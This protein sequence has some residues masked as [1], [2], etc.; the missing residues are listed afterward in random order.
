[1]RHI[2]LH[3]AA[4]PRSMA[5]FHAIGTAADRDDE[6]TLVTVRPAA[7]F[8][9]VGYHQLASR[10]IRADYCRARQIPVC[11]RMVGG[12]AVLLDPGQVFWHLI[13]PGGRA[14]VSDLYAA[15]LPA[16]VAVYQR[17]GVPAEARPLNDIMVGP[18]KIGGTGAATIGQSL[19]FV[20]SL[21]FDFDRELM[22]KVLNVPSE[23]FRD[24]MVQSLKDYMTTLHDELG[25]GAPSPA[26]AVALLV[27]EFSNLLDSP[28][29][30][31]TLTEEE[32]RLTREFEDSLFDPGFVFQDEGW[33]EERVKIRDGVYL[34][35]GLAKAP[36]GL[37]RIIWQDDHGLLKDVWIGG[38]FTLEPAR[39]LEVLKERWKGQPADLAGLRRHAEAVFA[40]LGVAGLTVDDLMAAFAHPE[41]LAAP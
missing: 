40:E 5:V 10:E 12:G 7:A 15:L 20:G 35:E 11:R 19:I 22:A 39:A 9:S 36:G 8:V 29:H 31:G 2:D 33:F 34:Y 14:A 18:K 6:I 26:E 28:A 25:D 27:E 24:K 16:P 1:M 37:V 3:T 4:V 23:K 21:M 17:L 32:E 38:D 13:L 30:S 41:R